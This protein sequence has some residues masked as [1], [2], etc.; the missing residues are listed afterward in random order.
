MKVRVWNLLQSEAA[1]VTVRGEGMAEIERPGVFVLMEDADDPQAARLS[2]FRP[3]PGDF[4]SMR[5]YHKRFP[6]AR[7]APT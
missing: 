7:N 5:G 2:G 4:C 1:R 3:E 6:L